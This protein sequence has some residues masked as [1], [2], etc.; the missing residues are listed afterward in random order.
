M[1]TKS[2]ADTVLEAK[3]DRDT[4]ETRVYTIKVTIDGKDCAPSGGDNS[5]RVVLLSPTDTLQWIVDE[6]LWQETSGFRIPPSEAGA[7]LDQAMSKV[8]ASSAQN[9]SKVFQGT[10]VTKT[11]ICV[12]FDMLRFVLQF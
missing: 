1:S 10:Q 8:I 2:I 9:L 4:L 6:T 3:F 7:N 5:N 11:E 12:N